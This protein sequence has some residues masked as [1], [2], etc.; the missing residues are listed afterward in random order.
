MTQGDTLH[1]LKVLFIE[2]LTV[3]VTYLAVQQL[4]HPSGNLES[5]FPNSCSLSLKVSAQIHANAMDV[6]KA[7]SRLIISYFQVKALM[8][9]R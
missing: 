7:S 6:M 2:K 8:V 4:V 3:Q 9:A 5:S 1:F